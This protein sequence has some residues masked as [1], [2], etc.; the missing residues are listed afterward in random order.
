MVLAARSWCKPLTGCV[1]RPNLG[2]HLSTSPDPEIPEMPPCDFKPQPYT[3]MTYE[4][5]RDVRKANLNPGIVTYYSKPVLIHQ[6]YMQY[7]YDNTGKRYLDLFA[8]I[9]TVGVGHCHPK[10][11]ARLKAQV[12]KLWHTTNIYM[13]PGIHE[14]AKKL[15]AKLP[16]DLKVVYFTNSGSE[17]NDLAMFM[18]RLYTGA[19]DVISLRNAYHGASPYITG[20]T[21]LSSWNYQIPYAFGIHHTMNPDVYRGPWGGS[22]CR[23]SLAQPLRE[24]NCPAGCCQASDMYV[25]QLKDVLNHSCPKRIAAF[26]A[27]PIQGV[28]GAVQLPKGFLKNAF[29]VVR[30][31]G[32]VCIADEVQTGFGRLGSHYWGFESQ[33]A[34]PDI[35]S[36]F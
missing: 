36:H 17:A 18:A 34:T 1:S 24:C 27:E 11:N 3:G 4:D 30:E 20:L 26:F 33:D 14:Y 22:N 16:G 25:D 13:H 9:V 19:F 5:T 23:D 6:G 7:L 28:G 21:A 29:Q 2:R 8:G 31:K 15:T 35:G 12:D 32:G 10:V